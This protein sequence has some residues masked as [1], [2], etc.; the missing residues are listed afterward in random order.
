MFV[1]YKDGLPWTKHGRISYERKADAKSQITYMCG[2]DA[3]S[4]DYD[5]NSDAYKEAFAK[6]KSRYEIVPYTASREVFTN[7]VPTE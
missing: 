3:R 2:Q 7:A 6:A 4:V 1:I 5:K